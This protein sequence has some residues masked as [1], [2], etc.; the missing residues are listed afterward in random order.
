MGPAVERQ[1][2]KAALDFQWFAC[3]SVIRTRKFCVKSQVP[4]VVQK[5]RQLD[6]HLL[7]L[8]VHDLSLLMGAK[9][10]GGGGERRLYM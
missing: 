10:G 2:T 3:R 4:R 5:V 1:R 7:L 9:S 8:C 6:N